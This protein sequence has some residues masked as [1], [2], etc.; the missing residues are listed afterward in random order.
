MEEGNAINVTVKE[1]EGGEI[2]FKIKMKT[3][4][5]KLIEAWCQK[6]VSTVQ[7]PIEIM[8]L[9]VVKDVVRADTLWSMTVMTVMT[10]KVEVE[11][12]MM[13]M[14]IIELMTIAI[15]RAFVTVRDGCSASASLGTNL[16]RANDVTFHVLSMHRECELIACGSISMAKISM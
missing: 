6:K 16:F 15:R 12:I 2:Q 13:V 1:V 3:K 4:I 8:G 14:V 9:R 7:T 11:M 10:E 5:K